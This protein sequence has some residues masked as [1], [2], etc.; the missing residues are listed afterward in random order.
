MECIAA[1]AVCVWRQCRILGRRRL[2][3]RDPVA[4]RACG[5]RFREKTFG[6]QTRLN[7]CRAWP[8]WRC[9][10]DK[11]TNDE[12]TSMEPDGT[13]GTTTV[14]AI[15]RNGNG[16]VA[17]PQAHDSAATTLCP[18]LGRGGEAADAAGRGG[19]PGAGRGHN[20]GKI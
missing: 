6:A 5:Q 10:H 7:I 11:G 8:R 12:R 9:R 4:N 20:D 3:K 14:S 18:G 17:L 2:A 1:V 15:W 19:F 16:T 13:G